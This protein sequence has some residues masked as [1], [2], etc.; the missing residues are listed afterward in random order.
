MKSCPTCN[1]TFE[2][3]FTFCL[4]DGSILS[5][6]FDPH[7][8]LIIPEPRQTE[9]SSTEVLRPQEEINQEIP[10]TVASPQP[11]QKHDELVSTIAAPAPKVELPHHSSSTSQSERKS[12]Q[13]FGDERAKQRSIKYL[14]IIGVLLALITV[15]TQATFA[16]IMAL[17]VLGFALLIHMMPARRSNT[18]AWFIIGLGAIFIFFF[19]FKVITS[20]IRNTQSTPS[21]IDINITTPS[22]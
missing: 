2:D 22:K 13:T 17:I 21:K 11:Q 5:A 12:K 8:T 20:K 3:T 1:R 19:I 4:V 16:L 15:Y 9:P 10:P 18:L 14:L 6:P 7:A